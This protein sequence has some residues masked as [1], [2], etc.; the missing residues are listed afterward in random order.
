MRNCQLG[1]VT[2]IFS[3]DTH[4]PQNN[5]SKSILYNI[6]SWKHLEESKTDKDCWQSKWALPHTVGLLSQS[7]A[8]RHH[9]M[10]VRSNCLKHIAQSSITNMQL[11]EF[12]LCPF[13]VCTKDMFWQYY[14]QYLPFDLMLI[15][16]KTNK[17]QKHF[18]L[19]L[20]MVKPKN[21]LRF[22]G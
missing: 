16:E 15:F 4:K 13:P 5:L 22:K 2:D 7:Q 12:C 1:V 3:T 21:H 14:L 6:Q 8:E 11:Y 17:Q 10:R 19:F 20:W 9:L 18:V